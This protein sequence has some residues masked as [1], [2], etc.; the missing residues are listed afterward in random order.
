MKK[1]P[2]KSLPFQDL[3]NLYL[4]LSRLE[5]SGISTERAM[6]L[7]IDESDKNSEISKRARIALNYLKRGKS[8][9]EAGKRAGLFMGLDVALINVAE[10]SGTNEKVFQQL[11]Q[12]YEAKARQKRQIKSRLFLPMLILVLGVFIQAVPALILG[13]ITFISYLSATLG[14]LLQLAL[15]VFILLHLSSWFRHGFLRSFRHLWDKIEINAPYFG[16]WFVRRNL[17][18]FLQSLGLMLEA[19]L[20]ILEALPKAFQV[21]EN[22]HLCQRLQTISIRLHKGDTFAEALSQVAEFSTVAHQ[23]ISTGEH[24]GSL[25]NMLR[26]YVK[27]ES[28]AIALHDEMLAAWLP[29][30]IY[31]SVIAM[32]AYSILS[33]GMSSIPEDL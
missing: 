3:A 8:L 11:A 32:M 15:F 9:S 20:P 18:N 6:I 30:I 16:H 23:L 12:F 13:K 29:R 4:Q 25:D 21:V 28:E 26:H 19:G 7:L 33:I 17:R 22:T 27:L 5:N 24:A 31:G 1:L 14:I 2:R 10:E